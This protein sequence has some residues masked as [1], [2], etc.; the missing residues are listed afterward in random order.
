MGTFKHN[1]KRNTGLVY[2]FL[3]RHLSQSMIEKNSQ[4]Y[5]KTLGL[6]RKYYGEAAPLTEEHELFTVVQGTRGVSENAAR[7]VL[8]EVQRQAAKQ[9]VKKL[10][11]KKS[12]LIKEI[13]YSFSQG[14]WDLHRI[15]DYRLLATIQ[16]VIDA[17]RSEKRLTESVQNIQLEEGLVQYMTSKAEYTPPSPHTED[18]DQLVMAITA[19]KFQEKYTKTLNGPQQVLLEKYIRAQVTGDQKPLFDV[20]NEQMNKIPI[21]LGK[22]RT[23]KEFIEDPIMMKK[24]DEATTEW[25]NISSS[26]FHK[27]DETVEEIMLFQKLVEEIECDA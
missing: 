18:I 19:K 16:M 24:L 22:A 7:R 21:S 25:S 3:V 15:P 10:D 8:G 9:D 14:F 20:I 1:K 11:I 26:G 17:S 27:L 23:M 12:N 6:I 5:Q 13:N 4:V 2:E